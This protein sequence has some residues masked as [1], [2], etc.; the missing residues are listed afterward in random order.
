MEKIKVFTLN[1]ICE[2]LRK[3]RPDPQKKSDFKEKVSGVMVQENVVWVDCPER[4][5]LFLNRYIL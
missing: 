5:S 3:E 1:E 2:Y 4:Q